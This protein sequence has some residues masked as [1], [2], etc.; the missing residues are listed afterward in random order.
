MK[1][2][3]R[4][5]ATL[6]LVG[7]TI[8]GSFLSA[9][10]RAL[11][12]TEKEVVEML[13]PVPVFTITD[14]SGSPLVAS[15]PQQG[16]QDTD[17]AVAGVFI[18]HQDAAAFVER[19]KQDKPDLGNQVRVVPVSLG[20]IYQLDQQNAKLSENGSEGLDFAFVPRQ[21][22]VQLAQELLAKNGQSQPQFQGVP[23]F[24]AKGGPEKGYLTVKQENGE[25]VIPFF[26]AQEQLQNMVEN[27]KKQNPDLAQSV[28]MEVVPLENVINTLKTSDN[29]QLN[30]IVLIP[31][32]E[33]VEFIQGLQRP[34]G[35][36][37]ANT[38]PQNQN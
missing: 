15:V 14:S 3:I 28:T 10:L 8:I 1:S 30:S 29:Q 21:Q 13:Q 31:S 25:Q 34:S 17:K 23:L 26:F 22:Q 12:L 24:F 6:G 9:N 35:Q 7:S 37:P 4:W 33:S 5:G 2:F 27:F 11:A 19:L 16:Q 20:D 32:Q 18:S 38:A 36:A